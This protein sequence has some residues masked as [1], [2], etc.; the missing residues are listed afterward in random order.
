[1]RRRAVLRAGAAQV[2]APRCR[3]ARHYA[4]RPHVGLGFG[5]GFAMPALR[6]LP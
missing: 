3:T 4:L 5:V 2:T 6:C 1:M